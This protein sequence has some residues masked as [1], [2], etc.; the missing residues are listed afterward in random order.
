VLGGEMVERHG[1]RGGCAGQDVGE[2][3]GQQDDIAWHQPG[4]RAAGDAQPREAFGDGVEGR[5]GYGVQG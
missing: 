4:I 1:G 5:A 3:G 2:A